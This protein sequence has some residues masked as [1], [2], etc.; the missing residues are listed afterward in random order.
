MGVQNN[1]CLAWCSVVWCESTR[2][3]I[4]HD[5]NV[6]LRTMTLWTVSCYRCEIVTVIVALHFPRFARVT[7]STFAFHFC[8]CFSQVFHVP[9]LLLQQALEAEKGV[10][11]GYMWLRPAT[12]VP[13]MSPPHLDAGDGGLFTKLSCPSL[14]VALIQCYVFVTCML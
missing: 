11:L 2:D 5:C 14:H 12:T 6:P 9:L 10:G 4:I 8:I 1:M 13:F 3:S 7:V